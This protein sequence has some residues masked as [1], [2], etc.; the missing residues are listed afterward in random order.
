[1]E[2]RLMLV[3]DNTQKK[4]ERCLWNILEKFRDQCFTCDFIHSCLIEAVL[5]PAEDEMEFPV[6]L[7]QTRERLNKANKIWQSLK[8]GKGSE[9]R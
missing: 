1:M 2:K 3:V 5:Q 8:A 6:F 7:K 9:R 4:D